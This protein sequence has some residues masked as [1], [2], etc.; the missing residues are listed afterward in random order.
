MKKY[1]CPDE[2]NKKYNTYSY[3]FKKHVA[4]QVLNGYM[5]QRYAADKYQIRGNTVASWCHKFEPDMAN[6]T[7]SQMLEV[8]PFLYNLHKVNLFQDKTIS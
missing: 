5:S 3:A 8:I 4:E 2:K 6:K 7:I 1:N